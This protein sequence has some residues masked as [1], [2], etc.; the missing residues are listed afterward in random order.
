LNTFE[1]YVLTFFCSGPSGTHIKAIAREA[2]QSISNA[3]GMEVHLVI[4]VRGAPKLKT[5]TTVSH[6]EVKPGENTNVQP[7]ETATRNGDAAPAKNVDPTKPLPPPV[8]PK[9]TRVLKVTQER[10]VEAPRKSRPNVKI[11]SADDE[12][13]PLK[14]FVIAS[15][16]ANDTS[17][18]RH[19]R[20]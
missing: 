7:A 11:N 16:F 2:E 13:R 17:V 12:S 6:V 4:N 20:K 5:T 15:D 18:R 9:M 1:E 14:Q 10:V 3:L 19:S 8:R